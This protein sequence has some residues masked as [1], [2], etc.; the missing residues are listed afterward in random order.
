M[1]TKWSLSEYENPKRYDIENKSLSDFP[2]LLSWAQKLN[3]QNE[4]VLDIACGTGRITI[5]FIENGYQ[6]IGVEYMKEC[7]LKRREKLRIVRR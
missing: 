6:M 5:P 2:F 7:L 3:I 4:W 1:Q